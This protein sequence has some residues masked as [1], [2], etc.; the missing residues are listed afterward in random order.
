M[1]CHKTAIE[2]KF[3]LKW[4]GS[5]FRNGNGRDFLAMLLRKKPD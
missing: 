1:A 2:T 5:S 3:V 4:C